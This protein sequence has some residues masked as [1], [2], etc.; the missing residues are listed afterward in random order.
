[1]ADQFLFSEIELRSN[2]IAIPAVKEKLDYILSNMDTSK[3]YDISVTVTP[4]K[5]KSVPKH[6]SSDKTVPVQLCK[7]KS[8]S[9]SASTEEFNSVP[10]STKK[11]RYFHESDSDNESSDGVDH[12]EPAQKKHR[13]DQSGPPPAPKKPALT[14]QQAY[15]HRK[16]FQSMCDVFPINKPTNQQRSDGK[17]NVKDEQSSKHGFTFT[18]PPEWKKNNFDFQKDPHADFG[19]WN[20]NK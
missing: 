5:I 2:A 20:Y 14:S 9:S 8:I 4:A 6:N 1:M 16:K 13:V 3:T 15:E 7:Q 10:G 19:W 12:W 17:L 11:R 18:V